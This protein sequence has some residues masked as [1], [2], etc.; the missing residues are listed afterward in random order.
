M[1]A[2]PVSG[3]VDVHGRLVEA[4]PPLL[5][6]HL[7]AGGEEGGTIAVPQIATLVRLAQRLGILISRGVIAADTDNDLDLWVRAEP[8][9]GHVRLT[10]GGWTPRPPRLPAP[11]AQIDRETDFL[12]A[13]AD[14]LWETDAEMRLIALSASAERVMGV[15]AGSVIGKPLTGLFQLFENDEQ[16]M[17]LLS[18]LGAHRAFS[19]QRAML[20]ET[21]LIVELSAVPML[22]GRGRFCGFRGSAS[23]VQPPVKLALVED[24]TPPDDAFGERLDNA[25]R[26]PLA[27]IIAKAETIS[28][29]NEGPLRRDYADYASDIASAGRHLLALVDDLVDLQAIER[30]DYRPAMEKIDLADIARR[31]SGLLAVRAGERGVRIDRPADNEPLPARGEF[32]RVLQILVNLI[33]NAVRYSPDAGMVWIRCEEEGGVA[34]V[35]V[36]DQGKGIDS[37][38]HERIFDKFERVDVSEPG[39]SGLGLYIARKLARA[40]GGNIL[41]DSAPGQG[42]RFVLTLPSA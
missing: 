17:P 29:Q 11:A 28:A 20:R 36:A 31:A 38:D 24:A 22:D 39:G 16:D 40:M 42:A 33:G 32:K 35:I 10:I 30:P 1:N 6:L 13:S 23:C 2:A 27:R 12:R 9:D 41:V 5:G 7:R 15:L 19:G 25:L 4:D 37:A 8:E 26:Q 34:T 18:G 14:W 3:R 21:S